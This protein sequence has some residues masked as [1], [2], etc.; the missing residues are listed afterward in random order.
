M[1][2]A[3][4]VELFD[5]KVHACRVPKLTDGSLGPI[6]LSRRNAIVSHARGALR[7]AS[8]LWDV[9]N[10]ELGPYLEILDEAARLD[11]EEHGRSN[12]RVE[13][14][15]CRLFLLATEGFRKNLTR[16]RP[17]CRE[18]F[19]PTWRPLFD[20]LEA[21]EGL[22]GYTR[23]LCSFQDLVTLHNGPTAP[24]EMPDRLVIESWTNPDNWKALRQGLTAF[25]RAQKLLGDDSIPPIRSL[26]EYSSRTV[27]SLPGFAE[28]LAA[29]DPKGRHPSEISV[30][31]QVHLLAPAFG[32]A[33]EAYRTWARASRSDT[34]LRTIPYA[35]NHPVTG[36]LELGV[37]TSDLDLV[38][39][40]VRRVHVRTKA[41][42][43]SLL[44]RH[45]KGPTNVIER[46]LLHEV[47][48][49]SARKVAANSP[50]EL[51]RQEAVEEEDVPFFPPTIKRELDQI[52]AVTREVY[53][54]SL[55][56]GL[57]M[58]EAAPDKW[59]A[60]EK[61]M[62]RIRS[63]VNRLGVQ[64]RERR[65]RGQIDKS[66]VCITWSQAVCIGVPLLWRRAQA[67]RHDF[68]EAV[69][70]AA[71]GGARAE[72]LLRRSRKRYADA[73]LDYLVFGIILDDGL[74]AKNY[75]GGRWN[76]HFRPR[77][78]TRGG[79]IV[80]LRS[81]ETL[82]R[83]HDEEASLKIS[84]DVR[85][86][87]NVRRRQILPGIVDLDLLSDYVLAIRPHELAQQAF[88][89][90]VD[91]YDPET[92]Q[93][94]LFVSSASTLP[95]AGY[96]TPRSIS[97]RFGRVLNEVMRAAGFEHVPT[98][99][100]L[101]ASKELTGTWRGLFGAHIA[102]QLIA[103]HFGGVLGEWTYAA[104]LTNDD[105]ATLRKHYLSFADG[106]AQRLTTTG[107]RS[108]H[109]FD[110]VVAALR[111]GHVVDWSTFDP[112]RPTLIAEAA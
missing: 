54:K 17:V 38:D 76:V 81:V 61:E 48:V 87:E 94:A 70:E 93:Y 28:R 2:F 13:A 99:A 78:E 89:P 63:H 111:A 35:F 46:S 15:N 26:S 86:R 5:A 64:G 80:G 31:E 42:A 73:L 33:M 60:V 106:L 20:A 55:G 24:Q 110:E 3:A 85:G 14:S 104:W 16:R 71:N 41:R 44:A 19:L 97:E 69:E 56:Q 30:T 72:D 53:G 37:D 36:L 66:L 10:V 75:A 50:L 1:T 34:W 82:W 59:I 11:A 8:G 4:A 18:S 49:M 62:E 43:T 95:S 68:Y 108:P 105:E 77:Y 83:G 96:S 23:D 58:I 74:R 22:A 25:R 65:I 40:L 98:M 79:R 90:S 102:R 88:I 27:S 101:R 109:H 107:P 7:H 112:N 9:D 103:N 91:A 92:D 29:A 67:H 39:L 6:S 21:A 52:W 84:Q 32:E 51:A 45:V 47:M 57:G 100:E 12:P